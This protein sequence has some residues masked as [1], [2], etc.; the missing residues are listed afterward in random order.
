M[1]A[2]IVAIIDIGQ[3]GGDA[4][5][6][7]HRVRLTQ[8]GLTNHTD[9]QARTSRLNRSTQTRAA[10]SNDQD[11]IGIRLVFRHSKDSPVGPYAH[12]AEADVDV[13][14]S[15]R[16]ET[17]PRPFFVV[18]I[19]A[20]HAVVEPVAA[21]MLGDAVQVSAHQV[22]EGMAAEDIAGQENDVDAQ[23]DAAHANSQTVRKP[24]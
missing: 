6:S 12:G 17:G 13:C 14:E 23:D 3:G 2:P 8:Q 10:R 5:F 15:Y 18:S 24:E 7:H 11:V 19:E 16:A 1:D 4:A 20:G 9:F 22:A 21:L